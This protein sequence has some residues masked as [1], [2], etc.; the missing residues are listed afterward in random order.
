MLGCAMEG[1]LH[2]PPPWGEA[3]SRSRGRAMGCLGG[4]PNIC[5]ASSAG[6]WEMAPGGAEARGL[7]GSCR[8]SGACRAVPWSQRGL[9]QEPTGSM[10]F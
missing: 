3:E 10:S 7:A 9:C 6:R 5:S 8:G 1:G 2:G 4:Y